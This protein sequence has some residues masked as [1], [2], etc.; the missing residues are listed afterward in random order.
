MSLEELKRLLTATLE[1]SQ[2][3]LRCKRCSVRALPAPLTHREL[4]CL[5][6]E[7]PNTKG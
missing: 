4:R 1:L 2:A 7:R 3:K 6:Y 5:P